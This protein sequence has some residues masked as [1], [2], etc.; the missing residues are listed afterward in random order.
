M[1]HDLK[2]DPYMF[3]DINYLENLM[4]VLSMRLHIKTEK[5]FF[6]VDKV[7]KDGDH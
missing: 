6:K 5:G 1:P 4:F 7:S 3:N 2:C